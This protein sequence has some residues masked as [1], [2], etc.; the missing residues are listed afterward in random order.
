MPTNSQFRNARGAALFA[1]IFVTGAAAQ[2]LDPNAI[3]G[4]E[5][6]AG[7]V[8]KSNVFSISETSTTVRTQGNFALAIKDGFL[9]TTLTSMP[10]AS[11]ATALA[12]LGNSGATFEVDILPP[13]KKD[14]DFDDR[15]VGTM[16]LLV[17]SPSHH[18]YDQLLGSVNFA[19]L[20]PGT[21][22]TVSYPISSR[23]QNALAGTAFT[24]LTFTFALTFQLSAGNT[25][26]FDNL[27]VHSAQ[28]VTAGTGTQAPPGYGGSVDLVVTG[29]NGSPGSPV[30]STFPIGPIQ[31]PEGFH[32]KI[33]TA[34]A[35]TSVQLQLGLDGT[36]S[37]NC[38][39]T[40]DPSDA[41]A[42]SYIFS[43]CTG[44]FQPGDLASAN[45]ASLAIV[46]GD[47]SM[48]IHAQL[49]ANPLGDTL[50]SG[51][52]PPMPTFWGDFDTCVPAPLPGTVVT[53]SPSCTNQLAEANQ[54]VTAY[55]NKVQQANVGSVWIV[56]PAPTYAT[57]PTTLASPVNLL[58][59]GGGGSSGGTTTIPFNYSGHINPGGSFDAYWEVSGSVGDSLPLGTDAAATSVDARFGTHVVM[60]GDDADVFDIE[61]AIN[62]ATAES[63]PVQEGPVATGT[64]TTYF[65]GVQFPTDCCSFNVGSVSLN[66]S[67]DFD[68]DL[69]PLQIWIFQITA[70]VEITGGFNLTGNV[71]PNN[72][73]VV[74]TPSVSVG[75]HLQGS[76]SIIV[77]SGGIDVKVSLVA[78][79]APLTAN[80]GW[81]FDEDPGTCAATT[82]GDFNGQL[83]LSSG[84]G[85]VDLVATFGFCPIC[86]DVSYP[87]FKWAPIASETWPL[88]DDPLT[89]THPLPAPLC[90]KPLTVAIVSPAATGATALA[91]VPVGLAGSALLPSSNPNNGPSEVPCN[92]LTWTFT[93]GAASLPPINGCSPIVTFPAPAG[94]SAVW[95]INLSASATFT[96]SGGTITDSGTATP[97]QITISNPVSGS[98]FVTQITD[99]SNNVYSFCMPTCEQPVYILPNTAVAQT[100]A[101]QGVVTGGSG[102][103][104]TTFTITDPSNNITTLT[105]ING[106]SSTPS[107]VWTLPAPVTLGTYTITMTTTSNGSPLGSTTAIVYLTE[108]F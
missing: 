88:F 7:W 96:N 31:V 41:T 79:Q 100:Y 25:Y 37:F 14:N 93:S 56:T 53:T 84:G 108:I 28:V 54:I 6:P 92:D 90:S 20:R 16:E 71:Q 57:H 80:F 24:D 50:G 86:H 22:N 60:F 18:I 11:T 4:F 87:L 55:F 45:W 102:T 83:T 29:G 49:A 58:P 9:L 103:L 74:F 70:G 38:T 21:Y 91:G 101:I 40:P 107:A 3:M 63:Y 12:G 32:L 47:S 104:A 65:G 19:K 5:T 13:T 105:S 33:G 75:A 26:L 48:N 67:H 15:F 85:E 66:P 27:R 61:G 1:V 35:G 8:V 64:I 43:S 98:V 78:V 23:V 69:P 44:G 42:A 89:G 59:G 94:T 17:S 46:N 10:V 76:I 39:Y 2:P 82:S 73:N 95:T 52:L 106:A 77:A 68:F 34:G 99:S 81:T 62:T 30:T 72:L 97:V 36:P 51:L